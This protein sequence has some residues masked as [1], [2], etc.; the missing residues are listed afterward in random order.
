MPLLPFPQWAPDLSDYEGDTTQTI[1]NAMPLA[2]G[3]APFKAFNALT[4]SLAGT[5]RGFF[6]ARRND[7]SVAIFAATEN[8]IYILDGGDLTWDDVSKGS[9]TYTAIPTQDQWQFAQFNNY[10]FAVQIN[11]APQVFDLTSSTNFADLG[12]SPPQARYIAVVGRFLFLSGLGSTI[13]Y[14]VQWS[15]L[16]ATTTWDGTNSSD[17]QDLPDGGIARTIG[18][19]EYGYIF[20]DQCIRRLTYAPGSSVIFVIER[21][22]EDRGI[23]APL[24]IVKGG[25]R[26]FYIGNDGFKMIPPGGIPEPIGQNRVDETFFADIDTS[27]L[28]LCIGASDPKAGIAYWA[29]KSTQ[30]ASGLFDKIIAYNWNLDRWFLVSQSGEYIGNLAQPGLTLENLDLITTDKV[31]VTGAANNGSGLI[32][33]AVTS[34]SGW[35]TGDIKAIQNVAGTTE[36][37]GNWTITVIDATHIDLQ[38]STFTH[39]Y[40]SGGTV[41]G[42]IELITGSFDDIFTSSFPKVTAFNSDHKA[43]FYSGSNL[44]A[45]LVT[46]RHGGDGRRIRVQGFRPI[47]DA[48]TVYGSV[49]KQETEADVASFSAEVAR[50]TIG[51]VPH[52]ISTRYSRGKVRIPAGTTW[53]RALGVE[54]KIALEGDR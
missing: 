21:I 42:S 50:N 38:G 44:E 16:A 40:T 35:T 11:T 52:N 34:T 14:R 33:L 24:S 30:G 5:C 51:Y 4:S 47:V 39:A 49:S 19:G 3:Y 29:Y 23:F 10:V 46:S 43:G 6:C 18:G 27:N 8:K 2:R 15:G 25:N 53:T 22:S 26:I 12:G 7:S 41:A 9:T 32:R 28:Q 31:S 54:P 20:Q 13:P 1:L 48:T 17:F 36:A 45:T 37:N